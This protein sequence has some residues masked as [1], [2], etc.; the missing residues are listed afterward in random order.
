MQSPVSSS[1]QTGNI[2]LSDHPH[3]VLLPHPSMI[4][5]QGLQILGIL[6]LVGG[7]RAA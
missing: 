2:T 7:S 5:L 6:A 3:S 1:H 4:C